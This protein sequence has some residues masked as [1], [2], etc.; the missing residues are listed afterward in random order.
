MPAQYGNRAA[1][2]ITAIVPDE[3]GVDEESALSP[4]KVH[5]E[6]RAQA[7]AESGDSGDKEFYPLWKLTLVALPQ[8]GV[9]VMWCFI[10]PNAAPYM[11]HLGVSPS[12]ATLNNVAGPITG[13][14]TGPIIGAWSD[15]LTSKWG[16]RRPII[17]GGLISTWIAGMLFSASEHLFADTTAKIGFAVPMYWVMDVTINIL[18][19]PHR[20][21]VADLASVEQQVPMQVVFVVIMAIGNFLGYSIMQIYKVPVE[22]MLQLMALICAINTACILVQFAVAKEVPLKRA[23]NAAKGACA[24]VL[25]VLS[26]VRGMPCLLYHL[27]VVQCLVWTGNTAWTYYSSQWFADSV[28]QGDQHAPEGSEAKL[29]YGEG[30]HAFSMGGQMRSG[31]QLL[32]ALS[33]IVLL[34]KTSL[35]PRLIYAPCIFVGAIV[36]FLAGYIVGH[37]SAFAIIIFIFSIMPE[38]GSFAIPFGLVATLNKR[39]EQE[40]KQVS[41]ALQMALLNCCVTVGQQLCHVV[42]ASIETRMPLETALPVAFLFAAGAPWVRSYDGC[43]GFWQRS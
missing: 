41:T 24:P 28:F 8:L 9:Q 20:A 1:D 29:R 35:R 42:T 40:G 4:G 37:N 14:F 21:L 5:A 3:I 7:G 16:R 31:F 6:K 10:G 2:D 33:I 17:L 38:T 13:F 36:S 25:G 43:I 18:Q 19:T 34:L 30:M 12:L 27:A 39:A 15:R 22:H 26:S 11:N 23:E 32:A